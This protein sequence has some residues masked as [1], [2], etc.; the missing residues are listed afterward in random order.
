MRVL[1]FVS[2]II[3]GLSVSAQST[4]KLTATKDT[5]YGIN[6]SLPTTILDIT[7]EA[8]RTVKKPGVFFKY[9]KKYLDIDN[10]ITEVQERWTVKSI[11]INS[12]GVADSSEEYIMQ[13]KAGSTAFVMFND[14]RLPIAI[15][16]ENVPEEVLPTLPVAVASVPSPLET[17]AAL[18]VV[19]EEMLQSQSTAKRAELAAA[20][21][22]ALRQS[23]TEL[24]TGQSEQL[25]P[26]GQ[27]MQL[28][29]D[30]ISAQ[31]AALTAMFIG[32]VQHS[33]EVKT[34]EY[35][36]EKEVTNEVIARLSSIDG[37]VDADDLS[38]EP[39][40][41]TLSVTARGKLPVDK[42]GL[43]IKSPKGGVA[44]RIPGRAN[45]KI[46]YDGNKMIEDELEVAQYGVVFALDPAI[47]TDKKAPAYLILNPTTGG[48]KEKGVLT[49]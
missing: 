16:T 24:I 43:E 28:V 11:V 15:N 27:A 39:I 4:E 47:F 42:N 21:I 37:I 31:E 23:R 35:K 30:N 29:L 32:T 48:I 46:D 44:Y 6:Y 12:R 41:L 19:N 5:K 45:V 14:Q 7:I 8:E 18:Q 10:P 20:Q 38:G 22:Y 9:A 36:P 1:F 17:D 2:A 3:L 33:T 34:I 49:K 40:Y 26:D 25:P 13:F